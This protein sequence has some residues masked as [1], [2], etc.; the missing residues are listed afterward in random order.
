M[1]MSQQEIPV[2]VE[3]LSQRSFRFGTQS[4]LFEQQSVIEV[5]DG[6]QSIPGQQRVAVRDGVVPIAPVGEQAQIID[7]RE[8]EFW[9]RFRARSSLWRVR[10]CGLLQE[11]H[12]FGYL[13]SC[14][15]SAH[16]LG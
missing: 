12:R 10:R 11:V 13:Y 3:G 5:H 2:E 4:R 6:I 7:S 8:V 16:F 15:L 14:R 9:R 1:V